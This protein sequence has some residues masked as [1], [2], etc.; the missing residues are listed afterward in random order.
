MLQRLPSLPTPRS[1]PYLLIPTPTS[2]EPTPT[3]CHKAIDEFLQDSAAYSLTRRTKYSRA[4]LD[5]LYFTGASTRNRM[6]ILLVTSTPN[7]GPKQLLARMVSPYAHYIHLRN[8]RIFADPNDFYPQ[9]NDL[10]Q[11]EYK[12]FLLRNN[13]STKALLPTHTSEGEIKTAITDLYRLALMS[14]RTL[15]TQSE[16][17]FALTILSSSMLETCLSKQIEHRQ[18]SFR[19]S[20]AI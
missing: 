3:T 17:A 6:D 20:L 14:S 2:P 12:E 15:L 10:Q 13:T 19:S 11:S 1:Q 18:L 5:S 8:K 16:H 9:G 7:D 4:S